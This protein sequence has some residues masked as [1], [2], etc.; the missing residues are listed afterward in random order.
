[1][2]RACPIIHRISAARSSAPG[3]SRAAPRP[4]AKQGKDLVAVARSILHRH[5]AR[6]PGQMRPL[7]HPYTTYGARPRSPPEYDLP[8]SRDRALGDIRLG[9][10]VP[11][12]AAAA[13]TDR[14]KFDRADGTASR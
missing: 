14:R 3:R 11:E 12:R 1:M 4:K 9:A 10:G 2:E 8:A 6:T 5:N 7:L 13:R